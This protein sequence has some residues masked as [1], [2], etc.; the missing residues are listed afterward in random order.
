MPSYKYQTSKGAVRWFCS[1]YARDY[2]GKNR[3]IKK[4]GF[5][6]KHDADAWERDYL[7][8]RSGSAASMTVAQAAA[9]FIDD[10]SH[11][12]KP[13]TVATFTFIFNK[14][15]LPIFGD[16]PLAEITAAD[17]RS[18]ENDLIDSGLSAATC[19]HIIGRLS[20][21]FAF[22]VRLYGLPSNPV[23]LAGPVQLSP[24]ASAKNAPELHFWTV[25]QF[26][27]FITSGLSPAYITLFS[28][29]FW[30]G[31]RIG[32]ALALTKA[33][34][35][36]D[37]QTLRINK[38]ISTIDKAHTYIQPPKTAASVR[39]IAIPSHLCMILSDW[40]VK[41]DM[42]DPADMFFW[43]RHNASV[44]IAFHKATAAAGL[45]PIRVH[46]LRHSHASMLVDMGF[47]PIVIRDRLGH[48]DIQTT[49][50]IYSHLYPQKQSD[51]RAAL[52]QAR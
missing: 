9:N 17:V 45:P 42:C 13:S 47:P 15:I 28:I 52:E 23:R 41:T 48:K 34:F 33:D 16:R 24:A 39:T 27:R 36:P 10:L 31:C 12:R 38:T 37:A 18:W 14:H 25:E 50:N 1:F 26:A 11:R 20:A 49:L 46:D 32:E 22:A 6:T 43:F 19:R 3:K 51:V 4:S 21:L 29:L 40:I 7:T 35:S 44:E 8:T 2:M 5:A 30:T